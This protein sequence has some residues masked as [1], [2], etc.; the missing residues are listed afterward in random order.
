MVVPTWVSD[1]ATLMLKAGT[2]GMPY[3]QDRQYSTDGII[4]CQHRAQQ[5]VQQPALGL[6]CSVD[7]LACLEH[8]SEAL[9]FWQCQPRFATH[10]WP[11]IMLTGS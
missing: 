11:L 8:R 1:S 10:Y 7:G 9:F 6:L 3:L 2:M 4:R 5:P